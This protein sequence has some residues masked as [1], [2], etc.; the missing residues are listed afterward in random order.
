ML[1]QYELIGVY[2]IDAYAIS[3]STRLFYDI[4]PSVSFLS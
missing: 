3:I 2:I 1:V 4:E